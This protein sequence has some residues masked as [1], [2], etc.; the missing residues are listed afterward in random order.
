MTDT[1]Y[2][3]DVAISFAGEDRTVAAALVSCLRAAGVNVFYADDMEADLWGKDLFQYFHDVYRRQAKYC[4]VLVSRHY[5]AKVW[6]RHELRQAQARSLFEQSEYILPL[7]V[8]DTELPG[9]NPTTAYMD[10][11]DR[12]IEEIC[13]ALIRKLRALK[14]PIEALDEGLDDEDDEPELLDLRVEM[15]D[16]FAAAMTAINGITE[17]AGLTTVQH[18]EEWT[19]RVNAHVASGSPSPRKAMEL[20]AERAESFGEQARRIMP[21]ATELRLQTARFFDA[22]EA[23]IDYQTGH[24]LSAFDDL[25]PGLARFLDA[26]TA[27]EGARDTYLRVIASALALKS[28]TRDFR[29]KRNAFVGATSKFIAA[30]EYWLQRSRLLRSKYGLSN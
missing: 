3:Y 2:A 25:V 19:R 7:R 9:L 12:T 21:L 18:V 30:T 16:A 4:V 15:D 17:A 11:R 28:V 23:L 1:D 5:A 27:V 14:T 10:A 22:M 6:T 13:A 26:D 8:D 24:G 20:V 29:K